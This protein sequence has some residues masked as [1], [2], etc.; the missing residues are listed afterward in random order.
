M[1]EHGAYPVYH[2]DERLSVAPAEVTDHLDLV[3][4]REDC[5]DERDDFVGEEG[6]AD[7]AS[8]GWRMEVNE[9]R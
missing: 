9:D 5:L 2:I 4:A 1:K 6:A 3:P 8:A 7:Y